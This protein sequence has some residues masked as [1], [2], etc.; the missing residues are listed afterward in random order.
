MNSPVSAR[1][2]RS[3]ILAIATCGVSSPLVGQEN[4]LPDP[5]PPFQAVKGKLRDPELKVGTFFKDGKTYEQPSLWVGN[6][7]I[8][9]RETTSGFVADRDQILSLIVDNR[10]ILAFSFWGSQAES[11]CGYPFRLKQGAQPELKADARSKT[12]TYFKPYML[13]G[14]ELRCIHA[15]LLTMPGIPFIYYGDEIGM[16]YIE[17]L[18]SKE[19]SYANRTG[20][21][22]PM[23]WTSGRNKGFSTARASELYLPLD[24]SHDAPDVASQLDDPGSHLNLIRAL[25]ALRRGHVALGNL[26]EFR[27]LYARKNAYP[28][29][30]ERSGDGEQFVVVLNPRAEAARATI[31]LA[32]DACFEPVFES[33]ITLAR[34]RGRWVANAP[35]ISWGLFRRA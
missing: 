34:Q 20:T 33:E 35:A 6:K 25:L 19:G 10:E 32:A 17:G 24:P 23:Q 4:S 9:V 14:G 28:F 30:Y 31:E 27:V 5:V 1:A 26:G 18:Q 22:T 21:R 16:N 15:M 11:G 29:V 7:R 2:I 13:P 8:G 3:L 12:I